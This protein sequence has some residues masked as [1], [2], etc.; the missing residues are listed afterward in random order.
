MIQHFSKRLRYGMS[1][2]IISI[3]YF[4]SFQINI[5]A[6]ICKIVFNMVRFDKIFCEKITSNS[7]CESVK[8]AR[9]MPDWRSVTSRPKNCLRPPS[10]EGR[11]STTSESV[12]WFT[13]EQLVGASGGPKKINFLELLLHSVVID[14][15]MCR[16][17][18]ILEIRHI[19]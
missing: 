5:I 1:W 8:L 6:I 13:T 9:S 7:G 3:Q 15:I 11:H 16:K 19:D 12:V 14:N 2:I 17:I 4:Q 10:N 18:N